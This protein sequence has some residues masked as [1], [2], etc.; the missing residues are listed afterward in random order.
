MTPETE[1]VLDRRRLRRHLRLWRSLAI[2]GIALAL[3]AFL[4][5]GDNLS[6]LAAPRQIARVAIEGTITEDRDQLKL[7]KKIEEASYVEALILF[8]NSPG[9]TTTGGE[10]LYE[11]LRDVAKVKPVVAQFGTVAASAG[12]IVGLGTDYIVARGNTITGSVGVLVQWPEVTELLGKLGVK[13]NSVKSGPLKATP[14]PFEPLDEATRQVTQDMIAESFRWFVSL[15]ESRRGIKVA[16]IPGLELGRIFS[17]REAA[18]NRLVDE[19]GGEAEAVRWLE[20][21]RGITKDLKVV[22]WKPERSGGWGG[23]WGMTGLADSALGRTASNIAS[24]LS[25]DPSGATLGLDG[26]VSVWHP[27]EN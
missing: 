14:N 7:L 22:D 16:D 19:I 26:L 13:M 3:G 15:V 11:A 21:K 20:E 23:L 2:V 25:R 24:L 12:Y 4:Y 8:V 17:G 1:T 10:S 9:G 5:S 27:S 18:A 6:G